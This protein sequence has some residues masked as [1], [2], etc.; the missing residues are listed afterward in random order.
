MGV[1][2]NLGVK[3][4]CRVSGCTVDSLSMHT[5]PPPMFMQS[6]WSGKAFKRFF[7]GGGDNNTAQ[8]TFQSER[9]SGKPRRRDVEKLFVHF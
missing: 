3:V 2:F 4:V 6:S 8:H 1:G 7:F 9:T 5:L